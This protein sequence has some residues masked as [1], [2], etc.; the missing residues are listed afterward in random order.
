MNKKNRLL[1]Q[2]I[3]A[4]AITY[5]A[6]MV[7]GEHLLLRVQG[8]ILWYGVVIYVLSIWLMQVLLYRRFRSKSVFWKWLIT[9]SLSVPLAILFGLLFMQLSAVLFFAMYS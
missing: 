9:L 6:L 2:L 4:A 3:I 7:E 8:R 5:I 1:V